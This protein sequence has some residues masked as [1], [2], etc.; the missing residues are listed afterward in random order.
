MNKYKSR[1]VLLAVMAGLV[2][3]A[4]CSLFTN[5]QTPIT[6]ASKAETA[7]DIAVDTSMAAWDDYVKQ[8]HPPAST[9]LVVEKAFNDYKAAELAAID[10]TTA[11]ANATGSN[12]VTQVSAVTA[13]QTQVSQSLA[14]LLTL[15]QT[16][17]V[18]TNK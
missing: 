9:E 13:A 17:T 6:V 7:A 18:N 4:G 1:L 15:V 11:Y 5:S 10:A 14:E 2:V 3:C 16:T 8:Y 12:S